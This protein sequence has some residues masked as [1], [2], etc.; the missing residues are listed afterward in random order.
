MYVGK[1]SIENE[2]G[3]TEVNGPGGSG[4]LKLT[5]LVRGRRRD[6]YESSQGRGAALLRKN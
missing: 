2:E 1:D 5:D 6:D 4:I 3:F